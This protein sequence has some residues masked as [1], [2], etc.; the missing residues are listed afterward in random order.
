M[1][2]IMTR[3]WSF[4]IKLYFENTNIVDIITNN[5]GVL[6]EN[7]LKNIYNYKY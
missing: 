6:M 4:K 3:D 2:C 7:I 5:F 1:N